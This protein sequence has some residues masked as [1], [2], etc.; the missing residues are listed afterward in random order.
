LLPDV[1]AKAVSKRTPMESDLY[2]DVP[3]AVEL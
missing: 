1:N 3:S 2:M